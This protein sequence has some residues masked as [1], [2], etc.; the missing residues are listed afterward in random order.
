MIRFGMEKSRDQ[1]PAAEGAAAAAGEAEVEE[2]LIDVCVNCRPSLNLCFIANGF[3][4]FI[5]DLHS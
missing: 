5:L 2:A 1:D 3:K 4:C